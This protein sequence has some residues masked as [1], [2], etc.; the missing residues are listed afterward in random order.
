MATKEKTK[1]SPDTWES[2]FNK[3]ASSQEAMFKKW[4]EWYKMMYAVLDDSN[5]APW[6]SKIFIPILSTKAWN[7]IAKFIQQEPGFE[8]TVRNN[9]DQEMDVNE[10]ERVADKV[11]RK[12]E[13]DYHNP[14]LTDPIPD[15][16]K[17]V[18]EDAVVTGTGLA[19]VP[20]V[21]KTK[22]TR[23][24][25]FNDYGEVDFTQDE[26]TR[27]DIGYNDLE[28]VNIFN[29]FVAPA[30]TSFQSSPWVIIR[31]FKSLDDLKKINEQSPVE[32][33]KNLSQIEGVS[34]TSDRLAQYSK[35]RQN[36]TSDQ[37][38]ISEDQ[39]V[40]M[41]EL[42][43]CYDGANRTIC[44]YAAVANNKSKTGRSWVE[45]RYQKNP[46]WHGKFPL[47]PFYIRRRPYSVWG[48]GV[49]E[50]TERLQAATNDVFNHYMDNWNLSVDG[51][52]MIEETSRVA[53]FLVE[54]GFELVY[55][56]EKPSQFKFPEPNPN[57]LTL[58]YTELQKSIEQATISNYAQGTPVSGLDKTQGTARGT[59][60]I[61]EA[62]TDMIQYMR[63]NFVSSIKQVGQ[64]WLSNNRQFMNFDAEVPVLKNNKYEV[65][66]L[67]PQ[68]MQLQMQLRINDMDM[69]PVSKQQ[70]REN[71]L[72]YMQQLIQLQTASLNQSQ[73]TGDQ[74]QTIFIDYHTLATELAKQ[75]S[76]KSFQKQVMPNKEALAVQDLS[77]IEGEAQTAQGEE[78]TA[79]ESARLALEDADV[80]DEE[81]IQA[82]EEAMEALNG[83][84]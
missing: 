47:V 29:V 42:F 49:F 81:R 1:T 48:E 6:R 75:F 46:Y 58:V 9:D 44:T 37:D 43:E 83:R 74:N 36:L 53:D 82:A 19:K 72:A 20:W 70:R 64:Q 30:A 60:A 14:E 28:P 4:S 77:D 7:M 35:S 17:T 66:I 41:V 22:E 63:D 39:T 21:S 31:E 24:H 84:G 54:P 80:P 78:A 11:Q 79:E 67:T 61:L 73:I 38:A 59:M 52:I 32:I 51:G 3:A 57:Q 12:L 62:A 68:E 15:K 40:N 26:I 27:I 2:R 56:G 10:L 65:E 69:Q 50:T 34:S 45:L 25:P 33:Y 18:L 55:S 8:V 16:L 71:Y 5:I 23:S 76:I 13:M